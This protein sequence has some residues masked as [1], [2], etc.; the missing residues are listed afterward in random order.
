MMGMEMEMMAMMEGTMGGTT[1]ALHFSFFRP[2]SFALP[3]PD[4]ARVGLSTRHLWSGKGK[5]RNG[6]PRVAQHHAPPLYDGHHFLIG[7]TKKE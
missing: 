1:S 6:I 5:G 2:F 3:F 7:E 4:T